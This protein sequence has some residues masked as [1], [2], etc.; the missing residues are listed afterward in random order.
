MLTRPGVDPSTHCE[1]FHAHAE[2]HVGVMGGM[3]LQVHHLED[4]FSS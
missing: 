4:Q 2:N 1:G 3:D